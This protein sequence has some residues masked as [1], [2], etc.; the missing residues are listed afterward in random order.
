MGDINVTPLVD[1]MLVLLIVFMVAAPMMTEGL[2]VALPEATTSPLP[3]TKTPL[4][5]TIKKDGTLYLRKEQLTGSALYDELQ[6]M[7]DEQKKQPIY[8]HANNTTPKI[9]RR[10]GL[11]LKKVSKKRA[12]QV[13]DNTLSSINCQHRPV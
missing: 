1:V 7:P 10:I 9:L 2:E 3:Q 11:F 12:S 4:V 5:V 13:Y 6:A 8:L